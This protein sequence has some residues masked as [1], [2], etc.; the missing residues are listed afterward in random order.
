V[1]SAHAG[2]RLRPNPHAAVSV[3]VASARAAARA[4][5]RRQR[6]LG[7]R[8]DAIMRIIVGL[9]VL[10]GVGTAT[11]ARAAAGAAVYGASCA[12]M[13]AR[14]LRRRPGSSRSVAGADHCTSARACRR[15]RLAAAI[16]TSSVRPLTRRA[17]SPI[18]GPS[19]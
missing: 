8:K 11:A 4:L 12:K 5:R 18:R 10:I 17:R 13:S 1:S 19:T 9:A 16:P 6:S 15:G 14:D 2:P 3:I 7:E